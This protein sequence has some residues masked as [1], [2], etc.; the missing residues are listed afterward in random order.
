[1]DSHHLHRLTPALLACSLLTLSLTACEAPPQ[2]PTPAAPATTEDATTATSALKTKPDDLREAIPVP[3]IPTLGALPSFAD[4]V[5]KTRP[6]VINIYTKTRVRRVVQRSPFAPMVPQERLAES[7]GSGFIIDQNGLALTNY[8][9]IKN[10]TDVEVRLLDN[11]RFKAKIVGVDPK[12]DV[13]LLHIEGAKDLPWL[14]MADSEK[15]KVGEWA[16]AIGNPLGLTSTVTAGIISAVGRRDVPLNGDMMYQ[17]FIQT[18]ASINPGNSGGPLVNIHGEVV[19]INTA[20]SA[21]GQG[22][23]FAIPVNMIQ[24]I[25]PQLKEHGKVQR[26]WLGIYVEDVPDKLRSEL[27][28]H[29]GG[30]LVMRVVPGGPAALAKL[31]PGDVIVKFDGEDILDSSR[32]SWT[33]GIKGVGK[34]VQV[35]LYRGKQRM[36]THLKLGSLPN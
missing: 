18:D 25:L 24:Q 19:G 10:A 36:G 21:E 4:L 5:E 7:L 14:P 15:L 8:H 17:D 26:S 13:A 3:S 12:T 9:V 35:E 1:M 23:G 32:L 6:S 30:A 27:G 33:A 34:T 2:P 22:I 31:Q 20:V 28:L 29:E 16:V 11:R